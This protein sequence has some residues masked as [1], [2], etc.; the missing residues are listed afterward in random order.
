MSTPGLDR[1]GHSAAGQRGRHL[2]TASLRAG[3]HHVTAVYDADANYFPAATRY[4][5]EVVKPAVA[6]VTLTPTRWRFGN[7]IVGNTKAQVVT[8]TD[9]GDG[10]YSLTGLSTDSETVNRTGKS[11]CFTQTL[12]PG[13]SCAFVVQ[14][15][16]VPLAA[17]NGVIGSSSS[18]TYSCATAT[19][20][21]VL[22]ARRKGATSNN[23]TVTN[24]TK[25]TADSSA[26]RGAG[27]SGLNFLRARHSMVSSVA[28]SPVLHGSSSSGGRQGQLDVYQM[29]RRWEA[30]QVEAR[31]RSS[32][33]TL[34]T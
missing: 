6:T 14:D 30:D 15:G 31:G 19:T 1:A 28:A 29:D 26:T 7:Q 11:T 9:T 17:D 23:M 32:T 34:R 20:C 3:T 21:T 13:G 22:H 8:L 18:K 33:S 27:V 25:V 10:P 2:D 12:R 4:F 16:T 24:S 5:A